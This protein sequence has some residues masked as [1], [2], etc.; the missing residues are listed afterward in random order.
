MWLRSFLAERKQQVRIGNTL[1][2]PFRLVS[3]VPQGSI[4][5]PLMFLVF[6]GDLGIDLED[7]MHKILKYVVD[8]KFMGVVNKSDDVATFHEKLNQIYNWATENNMRWNDMKFGLMRF[9]KDQC[10]KEDTILFTP[11]FENVIDYKEIIKDL[12]IKID[13][14]LSYETQIKN[15][16]AKAQRKSGWVLRTFKT[17]TVEFFRTMW[18]SL[19]QPHLDYGSVLWSPT[20]IKYLLLKCEAPLRAFTR[21]AWGSHGLNYWERLRLFRLNSNQRRMERY[22]V[23]YIW[24][25]LYGYVPSLG[26]SGTKWTV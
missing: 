6:I 10:I 12:G 16:V 25:S 22:R 8:S 24:K 17:R 14:E 18:N 2:D 3:G 19:I 21:K 20:D 7:E 11:G 15:A 9:G 23:I 13:P 1:S 26:L 5:G 4:M